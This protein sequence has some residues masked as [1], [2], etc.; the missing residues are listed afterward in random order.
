MTDKI[1]AKKNLWRISERFL[2]S[3]SFLFGG[4]GALVGME[5]FNHKTRKPIFKIL[6]PI[7]FI[8][9]LIFILYLISL[10]EGGNIVYA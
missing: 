3:C 7:A 10:H 6:I 1:K 8:L 2:I 5:F 4:I 9:T